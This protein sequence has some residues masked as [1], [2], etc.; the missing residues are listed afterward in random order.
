MRRSPL[1]RRLAPFLSGLYNP[2]AYPV[3]ASL[4]RRYPRPKGRLATCS[5]PVRHYLAIVRL[6]CVKHA[7]SVHPEPGSNS[8]LL[9]WLFLSH[10][11]VVKVRS[12]T[13]LQAAYLFENYTPTSLVVKAVFRLVLER[14]DTPRDKK[15]GSMVR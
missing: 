6:A 4:S 3:L 11:S 2:G 1:F 13:Y 9:F 7:A 12:A 5:S 14:I 15:H 8:P 10:F